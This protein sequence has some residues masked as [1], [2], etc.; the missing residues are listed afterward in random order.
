MQTP[1]HHPSSSSRP[2]SVFERAL[3][4]VSVETA[5]EA[6]AHETALAK[7]GEEHWQAIATQLVQVG[8]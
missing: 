6:L 2:L 8:R 7:A 3:Q 5:E 4:T 1:S